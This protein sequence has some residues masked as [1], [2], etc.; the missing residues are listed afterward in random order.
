MAYRLMFSRVYKTKYEKITR[1]NLKLKRQIVKVHELLSLDPRNSSLKSHK[2]NTVNF[3][4]A[5]SSS[6]SGD[7]RIIWSYDQQNNLVILILTLGSHSGS[8]KVYK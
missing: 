7:I 8:S 4:P 5:W 1:K 6:V 2:V 3:G